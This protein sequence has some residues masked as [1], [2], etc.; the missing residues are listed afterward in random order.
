MASSKV[1]TMSYRRASTTTLLA[2][3]VAFPNC[4]YPALVVVRHFACRGKVHSDAVDGRVD[5]NVDSFAD[6]LADVVPTFNS[7]LAGAPRFF[8]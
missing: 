2:R 6:D 8:T 7:N 3:S 5:A 1:T 4:G